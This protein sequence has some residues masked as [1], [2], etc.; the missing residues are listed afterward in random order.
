MLFHKEV[1]NVITEIFTLLTRKYDKQVFIFSLVNSTWLLIEY[2]WCF[3]PYVISLEIFLN[4]I[5]YVYLCK[6][7]FIYIIQL[8]IASYNLYFIYSYIYLLYT[9]P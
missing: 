2:L 3:L 4:F 5:F 8:Y 6:Q 9:Y 7:H 1:I